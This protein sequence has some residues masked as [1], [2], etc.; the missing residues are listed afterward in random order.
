MNLQGRNLVP[1]L[2][3]SDVALLHT[4]LAQLNLATRIV[5]PPG[6]FGSTTYLAVQEFQRR[7]DLPVTGVVDERTA[8]LINRAVDA[9]PRDRWQVRG[10][11]LRVDG[12]AVPRARVRLFEKHLR[13]ESPLGDDGSDT[14][15]HYDI[16]YPVP[17]DGRVSLIVRAFDTDGGELAASA[18]ICNARPIETLDLIAGDEPFRGPSEFAALQEALAPVL[19]SEEVESE[20]LTEEDVALLA[21]QHAL[22]PEQLAYFIVSAR[23]AREADMQPEWFY[24][25]VRQ[26][27][28]TA[29][30][31]L[32]AEPSTAL[33]RALEA[34]VQE[35]IVGASVRGVIPDVLRRLQ[36]QTV[37]FALRASEPDRPT[38]GALLDIVSVPDAQKPR[39]LTQYLAHEGPIEEFWTAL[40]RSSDV[41][42]QTVD[43]IQQV[44][45]LATLTLNHE[46]LVRELHRR[47]EVAADVRALTRFTS[48]DWERT[49][50]RDVQGRRIGA[51]AVLGGDEDGRPARYAEFLER[52]VE[53]V[54]PT[55]VLSHRLAERDA[56]TFA[57]TIAFLRRNP[58][59]D[60]IT[61]RV[62]EY[63]REHPGSI[64][65]DAESTT[66]QLLA[67]QRMMNI[68]PAFNKAA[69]VTLI[70]RGI[71]SACAVRRMGAPQFLRAH[72]ERFDSVTEAEQFYAN[73]ARQAD[74]AVM[75][76]AQ[77][78]VGHTPLTITAPHLFGEG[79]ADLEDLFGSLDTCRCESCASVYRSGRVSG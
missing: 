71:D 52:I 7:H 59:F 24:G 20:D 58:D 26:G 67:V 51:P 8:R 64:E 10:R 4:E 11:V 5:D 75:L 39:I 33:Q 30:L 14:Q 22:N 76:L 50:A 29:L 13:R 43:A 19:R 1:N 46:P 62:H 70:A 49:I 28:P 18:V 34:S 54:F 69:A 6:F 25:L 41:G 48:A 72:A 65:G 74:T 66:R 37:R 78:L 21:C 31:G 45:R 44:V 2:R 53:A 57:P 79:I 32:V 68:A 16:S 23:L 47:P 40:R 77:S 27:L 60:F 55:A 9:L 15:G 73:A 56:Q 12:Q 35:N 3:G 38:F 17:A 61:H 36:Q 63:L 42:D